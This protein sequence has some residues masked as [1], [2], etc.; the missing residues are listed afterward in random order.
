M[1]QQIMKMFGNIRFWIDG[2]HIRYEVEDS[3]RN[4][5][6]ND[7]KIK[8]ITCKNCGAQLVKSDI[9]SYI[10]EYCGTRYVID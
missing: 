8:S 6:L 9:S 10:C 5:Q 7:I 3:S 4:D 1:D 2:N